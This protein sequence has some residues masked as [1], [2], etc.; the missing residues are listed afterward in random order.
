[1]DTGDSMGS[2]CCMKGEH[3]GTEA[4]MHNLLGDARPRCCCCDVSVSRSMLATDERGSVDSCSATMSISGVRRLLGGAV[5]CW[6]CPSQGA[7]CVLLSL[8]KLG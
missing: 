3:C 8:G 2:R 5:T 7:E 1:M 4:L 6:Q